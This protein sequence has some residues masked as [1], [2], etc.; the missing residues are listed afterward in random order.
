MTQKMFFCGQTRVLRPHEVVQL[1]AA[2]PTDDLRNKFEALLYSGMKYNDLKEIHDI[3]KCWFTSDNSLH[4][5]HDDYEHIVR[6]NSK[7]REVMIQFL[8]STTTLPFYSSWHVSVS[9][10]AH[11]SGL[12]TTG[13]FIN[14]PRK[15]WE[16]WLLKSYPGEFEKILENQDYGNRTSLLYINHIEF[17]DGEMAQIKDF[18]KG[19]IFKI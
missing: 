4:V 12:D 14:T 17:S 10:W 13:I 18:T 11:N 16:T 5:Q 15:T 1:L 8:S 19:W 3:D 7:G 9:R 6:L 2:I